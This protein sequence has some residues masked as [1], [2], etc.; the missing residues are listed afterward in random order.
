MYSRL[1]LGAYQEPLRFKGK[2][3]SATVSRVAKHWYASINVETLD[4]TKSK[5]ESQ[6]AIGVDL[7]VSA[8]ATFSTGEKVSGPKAHKA[9]T[10]RLIRLSRSLS[11]KKKGSE[12]RKKAKAKLAT[13][14]ANITNIRRDSLHKLTTK[15]SSQF[16]TIGIEDL[17]VNGMTNNRHLARVVSDMGFF[18][19]RR[20]LTYKTGI[21]GGYLFVAD[22][23]YPSSKTCS[24]CGH[25]VE[26]L[27]L[28][29]RSWTCLTCGVE[30]DRD[31]NAAIN[32]KSMAVSS[33]GGCQPYQHTVDCTVSVC[34][35]KGAGLILANQTKPAS[36]KQKLS[37]EVC[38]V[39]SG[40]AQ[41]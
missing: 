28:S 11:R 40:F 30:H 36:V 22:R 6:G 1:R 19:F 13:L 37:R 39:M 18:E 27:P 29:V 4:E 14:H 21:N 38:S 24:C 9:L 35:E 34:G 8:L 16:D 31:V 3:M 5:T 23:W 2:I 25:K 7:D 12:N 10:P 20:Q 33:A 17:N 26:K 15:I 41:V 32:L